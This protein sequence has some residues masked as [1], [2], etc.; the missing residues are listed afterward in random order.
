MLQS[1]FDNQ[2]Q[3]LEEKAKVRL[4]AV[5]TV[6]SAVHQWIVLLCQQCEVQLEEEDE[7]PATPLRSHYSFCCGC[8]SCCNFFLLA[9]SLLPPRPLSPSLSLSTPNPN[10]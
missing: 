5:V 3:Q 6:I 2:E 10:V 8:C 9:L 4:A 7:A 1:S